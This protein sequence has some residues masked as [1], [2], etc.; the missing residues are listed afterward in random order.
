VVC[1]YASIDDFPGR[2]G[3]DLVGRKR[4][5]AVPAVELADHANRARPTPGVGH[6]GCALF[7]NAYVRPTLVVFR[8]P[9]RAEVTVLYADHGDNHSDKGGCNQ[10]S[11][12]SREASDGV[13]LFVADLDRLVPRAPVV[14]RNPPAS[15]DTP[16]IDELG[17]PLCV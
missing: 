13:S 12:G 4:V 14:C 17:Q 7:M 11:N 8:V 9:G 6:A 1:R 16:T 15:G 10:L 2:R 3:G 5:N